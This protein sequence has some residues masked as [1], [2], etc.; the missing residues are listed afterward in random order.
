MQ[1]KLTLTSHHPY[2]YTLLVAYIPSQPNISGSTR[3]RR[4]IGAM[5]SY[6]SEEDP[7]HVEVYL[8]NVYVSCSYNLAFGLSTANNCDKRTL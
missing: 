7:D 4:N 1:S 2:V 3:M 8:M 5:Q 6:S